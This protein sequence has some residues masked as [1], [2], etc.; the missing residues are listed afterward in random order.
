[1]RTVSTAPL[2]TVSY[3]V[4][5]LVARD[6]AVT[7]YDLK[8]EVARSIGNFWSFPHSQLYAEPAR[9]VAAGL[10]EERQER[11]GRRRRIY[12]LTRR[13][14]AALEL[15]LREA[16]EEPTQIRDLGLL[17][18]F[19]AELLGREEVVALAQA[20]ERLHRGRLQAYE[21]VDRHLATRPEREFARATLR[22]GILCERAFVRFWSDVAARPPGEAGRR[23]VRAEA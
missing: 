10:L 3:V 8:R 2:T 5:G 14:R 17:K 1:M 13:G 23:A 9:L 7:S 16:I 20:Q 12:S 19:F 6:G 22:M 11:S 21:E 18:L 4:L 15:W